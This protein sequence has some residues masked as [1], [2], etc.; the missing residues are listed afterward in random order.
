MHKQQAEIDRPHEGHNV[1]PGGWFSGANK[2]SR[3]PLVG[4]R[5]MQPVFVCVEIEVIVPWRIVSGQL[6]E[7]GPDLTIEL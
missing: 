4:F 3:W 7:A 5:L 1:S 2:L 6:L